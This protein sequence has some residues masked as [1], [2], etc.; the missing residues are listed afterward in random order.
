MKK[1]LALVLSVML[2]FSLSVPAFAAE[3]ESHENVAPYATRTL[4][5]SFNL[6]ANVG[7][8]DTHSAYYSGYSRYY[9]E[10]LVMGVTGAR[11]NLQQYVP[12]GSWGNIA[13]SAVAVENHVYPTICYASGT[14][15]F[16]L[17]T[18]SDSP[19]GTV[20]HVRVYGVS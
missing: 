14:Y 9:F 13:A 2:M 17:W 11:F 8:N 7:E 16:Q 3:A 15:Q 18:T 12:D 19:Y 10:F 4:I 1:I 5:D 20:I 6:A